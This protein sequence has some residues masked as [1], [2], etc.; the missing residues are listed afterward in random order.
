MHRTLYL[1]LDLQASQGS[2]RQIPGQQDLGI[3]RLIV[4]GQRF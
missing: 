4:G 2:G 3:T 1:L